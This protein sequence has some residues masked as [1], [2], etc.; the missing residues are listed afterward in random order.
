MTDTMTPEQ[1]H[2][3]MSQIHSKGTKPLRRQAH[4]LSGHFVGH[5]SN[6]NK[7]KNNPCRQA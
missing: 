4:L 2:R 6:C 3:F 5:W 7:T 1:R